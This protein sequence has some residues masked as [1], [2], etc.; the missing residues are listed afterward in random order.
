MGVEAPCFY[1]PLARENLAYHRQ[2]STPLSAHACSSLRCSSAGRARA[3]VYSL[4][5]LRISVDAGVCCVF[6]LVP[7]LA[8]QQACCILTFTFMHLDL[9]VDT[10]R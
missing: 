5:N 2:T 9:E 4:A 10:V 3:D 1:L 6:I 8:L 7:S